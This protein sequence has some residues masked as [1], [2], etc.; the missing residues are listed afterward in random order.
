MADRREAPAHLREQHDA[1]GA[2]H[3]HPQ[4]LK[5]E[6]RARER[7]RRDRADVEKAADAGDDAEADLDEVLH[8]VRTLTAEAGATLIPPRCSGDIIPPAIDRGNEGRG[9]HA[10]TRRTTNP[11]HG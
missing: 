3:D 7:R 5:S 10:R 1:R 8:R 4:Q 11:A 6:E 2:E 9:F